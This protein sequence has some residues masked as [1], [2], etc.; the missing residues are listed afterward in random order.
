MNL[1]TLRDELDAD[2]LSRGYASLA[3]LAAAA[4]LN[5]VDRTVARTRFVTARAMLAELGPTVAATI[6]GKLESASNAGGGN[7]ALKLALDA[8]QT[9][10][11]G[12]GLDV[13]H[14]YTQAMLDQLATAEGGN[15]LTTQE[16]AAVKAMANVTISRAQELGLGGVR[17]ITPGDIEQARAL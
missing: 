14:P 3:P 16:A 13:G 17:G 7:L 15:V 11:D 6:V 12:G 8:V 5:T 2:P 10:S 9:Y 1:R 4:S